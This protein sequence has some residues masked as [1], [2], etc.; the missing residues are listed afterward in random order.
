MSD[1]VPAAAIAEMLTIANEMSLE[2]AMKKRNA[3][4]MRAADPHDNRAWFQQ[5]EA[6]ALERWAYR[7]SQIAANSQ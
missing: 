7:L 4:R 1:E 2:A 3:S 6:E 5:R